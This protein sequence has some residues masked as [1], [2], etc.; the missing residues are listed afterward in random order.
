MKY[1][2]IKMVFRR[3]R[4]MMV[5]LVMIAALGIALMNGMF[6]AWQSLDHSLKAYLKEYGIADAAISTEEVTDKTVAEKIRQVDGVADVIAR[7]AGSSQVIT[8]SGNVLTAQVISMDKEDFLKLYYWDDTREPV[9]DYILADYW[10]A[11][12]NGIS[13]GDTLQ[14]RTG[15]NEYR[16]FLVAAVVSAPETIER[17]KLSLGGRYYPDF[18]FLYAPISLLDTETEKEK[19][20]MTEEWKEKEDEYLKSEKEF[21]ESWEEGQ[22]ELNKAREELEKQE[23]EFDEKRADLK[24][25]IRELTEGRARLILSRKELA[26]AEGTAGERKKE[27]EEKLPQAIEQLQE[28]EEKQADLTE[29]RNE[30]TGMLVQLEDAKGRLVL[31]R[32]LITKKEGEILSKVQVMRQARTLWQQV[33]AG[34]TGI[35]VGAAQAAMASYNVSPGQLN[36]WISQAESGIAQMIAG[37]NRIQKGILEISNGYLPEV[38]A[39]LEQT[40]QGLETIAEVREALQ[41]GIAEMEEGLKSI[42]DFEREAPDNR[43]EINQK[44]Q[45]VEEGLKSI[46]DGLSEGETALSEGRK[47][48]EEKS[49]EADEAH[50]QAAEELA[51]GAK[52]LKEAWDEL[53]AWKG[54]TPLRN[55]FLIWFDQDV[56]DPRAVLKKAEAVLDVPVQNSVLYEDSEVAETINDNLVPL[57]SMS[58][59]VPLIFVGI[60]MVVLFLFLSIMIRQSRQSIG[61]LRALGFGKAEVRHLFSSVCVILMLIASL[62]GGGISLFITS[63]FNQYFQAYFSL[64]LYTNVFSGWVYALT[65]AAFVLLGLLAA[66]LTSGSLSRIQPAEAVSR[67]V[68]MPPKVGRLTGLLLRR[69][70]PLSKFSLLSLRRNPFRFVSSVICITGAVSLIF[71]ALSFIVSKNEVLADAFGRKML[72]DAQVFFAD[73]PG[74]ETE[75]KIRQIE[76][77]SAA[78]RFWA[79]EEELSFRG[80]SVRGTLMF[81]DPDTV[82]VSLEDVQN[83][84]MEFPRKGI[85]LSASFAEA[86]GVKEG[87]VVTVGET[88]TTVTGISRQMAMEFQ[89]LPAAEKDL[90]RKAEETGWIIRLKDGANGTEIASRL[91][92]EKGYLTTIFKSVMKGA[93]EEVFKEFDLYSWMLVALCGI[94]GFFIVV[95]TGQNNLHEQKL[96]LSVLRAIGFQ[97]RQISARWFLQSLLY[98]VLSLPAG[99]LVGKITAV[100]SLELMNNSVRHLEYI[101][102][103][104]QYAWTAVSTFVFILAGHLITMRSMK[105]WD[106]VESTKGRE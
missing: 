91:Y 68:A 50:A 27:L 8:P 13:A 62:L 96:S 60:M 80:K 82:M 103:V 36:S 21:R 56:T 86:L 18:G 87:D 106:L 67:T 38:E 72:Y 61:I 102:A 31:A 34:G 84:P 97:H 71:T 76:S 93:Y 45:E 4:K 14:I 51:E 44:L 7:L 58:V 20:R 49:T 66:A 29:V 74:E 5:C 54:Y 65:V 9:G 46:Y 30:L 83:R 16:P 40:E 78:E 35:D 26:D 15:E 59:M 3:Y 43:E 23:N 79:R 17:T 81:L 98:L 104:F 75:E 100:R 24:E 73:D 19:L 47:D 105:K 64:P 11:S 69:V 22:A 99:Y 41:N 53:T 6:N 10:F 85:V 12:N 88:E 33:E 101:P 94:V 70:E 39:Y 89:Y 37:K 95:N 1:S 77:V 2:L 55:E 25:Q 42:S 48:L 32:D 63:I 92:R 52:S 90:Y 57:W 28:A